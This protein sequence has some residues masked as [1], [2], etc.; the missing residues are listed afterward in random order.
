M[1][2]IKNNVCVLGGVAQTVEHLPSKSTALSSKPRTVKKKRTSCVFVKPP[3]NPGPSLQ[4]PL[5]KLAPS[6]LRITRLGCSLAQPSFVP[7]A[8]WTTRQQVRTLSLLG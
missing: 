5:L 7:T 2:V 3:I 8:L 1:V 6:S 4:S